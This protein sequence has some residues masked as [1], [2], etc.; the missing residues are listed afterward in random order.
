M[1]APTLP[2]GVSEH[3]TA[4]GAPETEVSAEFPESVIRTTGTDHVTLVGSNEADTVAFYRDVLGMRLVMRQPNL[5]DPDS[6]HLF[7]DS[8]DG[9]IVTFFVKDDRE[10]DERPQRTAVGGVHHLAFSL[11]PA[12]FEN[13]KERLEEA[14]HRFSEFDR[15]AFHSLYTRDHN[16]LVIEL[17]VDKYEIPDDRRADVLATAQRL[18]VEAGAEFVDDEHLEDALTELGIDVERNELP[19]ADVGSARSWRGDDGTDGAAGGGGA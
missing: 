7:F 9:R 18:R 10:S 5:D 15:G 16:G 17:A 19:D 3:E 12:E 11:D 13:T 14:G 8:G 6:T 4:D 2:T 1:C